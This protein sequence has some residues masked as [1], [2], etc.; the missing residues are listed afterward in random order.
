M[1]NKLR[2]NVIN[3]FVVVLLQIAKSSL[4]NGAK[5]NSTGT[6]A[7]CSFYS[8]TTQKLAIKIHFYCYAYARH[9]KALS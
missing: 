3:I 2:I 6:A 5:N 1:T 4:P 8:I 9:I 7:S